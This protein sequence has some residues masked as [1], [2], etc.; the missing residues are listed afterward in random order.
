MQTHAQPGLRDHLGSLIRH[1]TYEI[2]LPVRLAEMSD[3]AAHAEPIADI[4]RSVEVGLEA[5]QE[6]ALA[7]QGNA[8]QRRVEGGGEEPVHDAARKA[9]FARVRDVDVE[10]V[11]VARGGAKPV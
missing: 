11:L 8:R 4:H 2:E 3:G 7:R 1:V 10:R 5:V 6:T 9:A